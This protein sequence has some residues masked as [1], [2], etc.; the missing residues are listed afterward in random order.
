MG[1]SPVA[2]ARPEGR[3]GS[4]AMSGHTG[5]V[6]ASLQPTGQAGPDRRRRRL[7]LVICC[8][9]LLIVGLD[10]T[11]VNV[12]LPSI[13]RELHTRVAGLQW[14]VD[15]YTLTLASLLILAGSTGDRLGRRRVFQA[16]LVTFTVASL[17]CSVS[18]SLGMLIA[19]RIL[20]A[21]GGSM[22]NPVAMGIIRNVF[23]RS[24][25]AGPGDRHLGGDGG[26]QPGARASPRRRPGGRDRLALDLLDQR[27]D[28]SPRFGADDALRPRIAGPPPSPSRPRGPGAGDRDAGLADLRDH[29]GSESRLDL[30][31]DHRPVLSFGPRVGGAD[32]LRA[33]PARTAAG[34]SLLPQRPLLQRQRHRGARLRRPGRVPAPEHALPPGG[35]GAVGPSRRSVARS[36]S[37]SPRS[38]SRLCPVASSGAEAPAWGFCW[39]ASGSA[40]AGPS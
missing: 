28:R 5:A 22:L 37:P 3:V 32:P 13:G 6:D 23:H 4:G 18:T 29:R 9:S 38:C 36:R 10:N 15:A 11:I 21:V 27:P 34:T 25:R 14:I 16:G 7:I 1:R 2:P 31:P 35:K 24:P 20:Q 40:S 12:A 8:M 39:G 17:L 33:P 26:D 19:F 30:R